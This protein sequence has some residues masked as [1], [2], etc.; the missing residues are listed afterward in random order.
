[1]RIF[2]DIY[3]RKIN[4]IWIENC[5]KIG[6]NSKDKNYKLVKYFKTRI[7]GLGIVYNELLPMKFLIQVIIL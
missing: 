4:N 1:M 5:T 6:H 7:F 3:L 2:L